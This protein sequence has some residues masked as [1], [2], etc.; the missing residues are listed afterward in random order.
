MIKESLYKTQ[1]EYEKFKVQASASN[2]EEC[3]DLI[4]Q[5]VEGKPLK[6]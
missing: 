5:V 2:I 4:D 6:A 3:Y 1:E